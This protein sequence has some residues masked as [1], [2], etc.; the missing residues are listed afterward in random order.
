MTD[1]PSLPVPTAIPL[2]DVLDVLGARSSVDVVRLQKHTTCYTLMLAKAGTTKQDVKPL[3]NKMV[4]VYY[5]HLPR[6]VVAKHAGSDAQPRKGSSRVFLATYELRKAL[7]VLSIHLEME[8][9]VPPELIPVVADVLASSNP[10]P[11]SLLTDVKFAEQ[12]LRSVQGHPSLAAMGHAE[13]KGECIQGL[14]VHRW[15]GKESV[16]YVTDNTD[17]LNM[18]CTKAVQLT[19]DA[20]T[21]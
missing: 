7:T 18:R 14:L 6:D 3:A 17:D 8:A 15:D 20:P 10:G 4:R 19:P 11:G 1:S 9:P 13:L 2:D 5:K 12:V 21:E 16:L